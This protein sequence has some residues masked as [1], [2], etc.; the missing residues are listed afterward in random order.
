MH[1]ICVHAAGQ[2][3]AQGQRSR[4]AMNAVNCFGE[5]WR[6]S[7]CPPP[8]YAPYPYGTFGGESPDGS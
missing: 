7:A 2:R 8:N 6:A 3:K 1:A 4:G 5:A